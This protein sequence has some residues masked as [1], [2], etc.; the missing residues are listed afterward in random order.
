MEK[1]GEPAVFV[2]HGCGLDRIMTMMPATVAITLKVLTARL[3]FS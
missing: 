3:N 1:V 2:G